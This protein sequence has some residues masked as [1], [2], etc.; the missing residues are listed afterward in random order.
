MKSGRVVERGSA[1]QIFSA[2]REAYTQALLRAAF[3]VA[4]VEPAAAI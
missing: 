2:P 3:D 1:D 4:A